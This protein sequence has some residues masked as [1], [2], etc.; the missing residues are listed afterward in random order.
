MKSLV[1]TLL[2]LG[3]T[4]PAAAQDKA[5]EK[6]DDGTMPRAQV[7]MVNAERAFS[8]LASERGFRESFITYFAED[9][10]GFNPHP[11]KVKETLSS[12]P[13][14]AKS[15]PASFKWAPAYGDIAEAGDL[16][17]DTG[18]VVFED[19]TP[20]KKPVRHGMFFSVWKKQIDGN[21]RVVLDLGANVPEAVTPLDAPFKTSYTPSGKR[22][23]N[24]AVDDEIT[25]L[26]KIERELLAAAKAGT[27]AQAFEG[28]LSDD[29]RVH[30]PGVMPKVGK[31][32]RDWLGKQTTSLSGE[33][34][35]ADVSRSGDLG[36]A[37]GSYELSGPQPEKGYYARVWKRDS[38]GE[39]RI[40][41]DTV[42]PI[43]AGT[44]APQQPAVSLAKL[45]EKAQQ[46][47]LSQEWAQAAATYQQIVKENPNDA[48]AWHR[49][50]TSQVFL[51]QLPD[52]IKN[53]E[54]AIKVGGGAPL[55]F[56]NL[57]CAFALSGDRDKALDNLEKAIDAGFTD[58]QQYETDGDLDSLR[59]VARFK[60]LLKRLR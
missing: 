8:K 30:R 17:W 23:A 43:P 19:T 58:R 53:L 48:V 2:I 34:I 24:V 21:W 3:F 35:K 1:I 38:S 28:R 49:L 4:L 10:I 39:W 5:H 22:R 16:G 18:P 54:Q 31:A 51:R 44:E 7:E 11:Y 56:Y 14:P 46:H 45:A 27:V 59:E 52:G 13:A 36:Y 12:Q 41:L 6:A 15:G 57:G 29:A 32:A 50:G 55:D 42:N 26:L 25:G 60:E 9:G 37:Y 40:V 33:P 20:E 47:Y